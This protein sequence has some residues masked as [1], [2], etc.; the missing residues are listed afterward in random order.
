M[1][2]DDE[3]RR[4]VEKLRELALKRVPCDIDCYLA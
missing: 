3:R 2:T 1:V 4:V